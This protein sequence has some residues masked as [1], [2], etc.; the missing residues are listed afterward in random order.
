MSKFS[1][2][3]KVRIAP[4]FDPLMPEKP[5]PDDLNGKFAE[6]GWTDDPGTGKA[7]LLDDGR[8]LLNPVPMAPPVG[9]VKEPSM[10]ELIQAQVKK[11]LLLLKGD[12]EIDDENDVNDFDAPEEVDPFSL[13]EITDMIEESPALPSAAKPPEIL[14]S[15][16]KIPNIADIPVITKGDNGS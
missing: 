11:H 6:A 16:E 1:E 13:Y 3:V 4:P 10:M 14:S 5:A 8:E 12:D 7:V 15:E 9:Y 2:K